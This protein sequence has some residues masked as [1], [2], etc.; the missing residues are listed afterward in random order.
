MKVHQFNHIVLTGFVFVLFAGALA[1]AAP[2]AGSGTA[3]DPYQVWNANDLNAIGASTT[4]YTSHFIMMADINLAGKTYT[5]AVIPYGGTSFTGVFDG[6]SRTISNL[7]INTAGASTNYLGLFGYLGTNAEGYN[8][9]FNLGVKNVSITASGTSQ[10]VGALAGAVDNTT[11]QQCSAQGTIRGGNASKRV[12][13]LFGMNVGFIH[14]CYS[15]VD[16]NG[17]ASSQFVGGLIGTN[18][19]GQVVDCYAAGHVTGGTSVGGFAGIRYEFFPSIQSCYYLR[20]SDGGVPNNGIATELTDAQMRQQSSFVDWDFF[21]EVINGTGELWKMNGYPV[22]SWQIPVGMQEFAL[23]GS[24]WGEPNCQ[25]GQLCSTVDWYTDGHIDIK[26]LAQ[27]C[28]SWLCPR[29]ALYFGDN[30]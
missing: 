18:F 1:N 16:V 7:T 29:V 21:G 12:G 25:P 5:N 24:F 2:W 8:V 22:L 23:L 17:G 11:I 3:E 13:G 4:Y 27:L 14:D 28:R 15:L 26:D 6:N 10:N 30:F 9:L 19:Y 20:L